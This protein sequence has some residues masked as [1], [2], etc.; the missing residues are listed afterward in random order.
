MMPE[1]KRPKIGDMRILRV[2]NVSVGRDIDIRVTE[3]LQQFVRV[4][5]DNGVGYRDRWRDIPTV[6]VEA[7]DEEPA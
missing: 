7:G 1:K 6:Y 3:R 2:R 4:E 5:D